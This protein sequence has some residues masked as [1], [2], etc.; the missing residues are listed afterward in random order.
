MGPNRITDLRIVVATL[1]GFLVTCVASC[2]T[3]DD[4]LASAAGPVPPKAPA[5]APSARLAG[6]PPSIPLDDR[7]PDEAGRLPMGGEDEFGP[8]MLTPCGQLPTGG[9]GPPG[10]ALLTHGEAVPLGED[11]WAHV[12]SGGVV[13][14]QKRESDD[15]LVVRRSMAELFDGLWAD[16]SAAE[17]YRAFA[18][19]DSRFAVLV[20]LLADGTARVYSVVVVEVARDGEPTAVGEFVGSEEVVAAA[21]VAGDS[22]PWLYLLTNERGPACEDPPT[23]TT[24]LTAVRLSDEFTEPPIRTSLGGRVQVVGWAADKFLLFE[25][26]PLSGEAAQ[27][28]LKP[29]QLRVVDL[30]G[31]ASRVSAAIALPAAP[32]VPGSRVSAQ[33]VDDELRVAASLR[34]PN[35]TSSREQTYLFAVRES[36]PGLQEMA[37]ICAVESEYSPHSDVVHLREAVFLSGN[38]A[39]DTADCSQVFPSAGPLMGSGALLDEPNG[40]VLRVELMQEPT[41]RLL[42]P[43]LEE[44]AATPLWTLDGVPDEAAFKPGYLPKERARFFPGSDGQGLFAA[45]FKTAEGGGLALVATSEGALKPMMAIAGPTAIALQ[46]NSGLA[47]GEVSGARAL[48]FVER[49]DNQ[50]PTQLRI[51]DPIMLGE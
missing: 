31:P 16:S 10:A 48:W 18:I 15:L 24:W 36:E 25:G 50:Q 11:R 34:P 2:V 17:L 19:S 26:E 37:R 3:S 27:N 40:Q 39:F 7:V 28:G 49:D 46:G 14:V 44:V 30:D 22:D 43:A 23:K 33:V 4:P 38:V 42:S 6:E 51:G 41:L 47:D 21:I 20:P 1:V 8:P 29:G 32:V 35:E 45:P 9:G 5:S 12:R 13:V